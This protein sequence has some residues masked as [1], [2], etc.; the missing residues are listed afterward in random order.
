MDREELVQRLEKR[1]VLRSDRVIEAFRKVPREE[2]VPREKRG[3]AYEDRPLPIG[4]GQTISAPHMVAAMTEHL[5]PGE[6]DRV[7]EIGTG[8]GYQAAIL[9]ELVDEVITTEIVP[10]LAEEAR[11]RLSDYGNVEVVQTDG[12]TGYSEEAPYDRILYT[13]AAP[14]IPSEVFDQLEPG[15]KLVAPVGTGYSQNLK[16][17]TKHR[18]GEITEETEYGVRFVPLTGEAGKDENL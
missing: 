14:E 12:S 11:E 17:Y 7:L 3:E 10:E 15:G 8:S 5:E 6:N 2:F 1:G 16:I 18:E 4:E 9:S 13:A